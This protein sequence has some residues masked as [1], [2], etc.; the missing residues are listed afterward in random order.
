MYEEAAFVE[1]FRAAT[2]EAELKGLNIGSRPR[3]KRLSNTDQTLVKRGS[4]TQ[5]RVKLL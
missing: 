4:N 1:Y 3:S 5:T 2:P